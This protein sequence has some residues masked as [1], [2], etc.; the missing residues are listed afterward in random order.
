MA[1]SEFN[2]FCADA[3]MVSAKFAGSVDDE[4][5]DGFMKNLFLIYEKEGAPKNR[6]KWLAEKLKDQFVF[7]A[8]PP[9][10]VGEPR[11]AY[12]DNVP[13]VF[14]HQFQVVDLNNQLSGR[15]KVGDTVFIFGSKTPPCPQDEESWAVAYRMV[16]QTEEGEDLYYS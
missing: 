2:Y 10:W 13:M 4:Q 14:L 9:K 8:E 6:K 11:W 7:M 3:I 16:V 15:L 1:L 12:L 5:A